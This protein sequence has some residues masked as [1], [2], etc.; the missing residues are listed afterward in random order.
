MIRLFILI[1]FRHFD[2]N[3]LP[4]L[5]FNDIGLL[6]PQ[7]NVKL[8]YL[9]GFEPKAVFELRTYKRMPNH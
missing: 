6:E 5:C 2:F 4:I 3:L 1:P 9:P 8:P 7:V